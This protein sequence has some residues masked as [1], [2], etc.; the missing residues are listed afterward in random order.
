ML[1]YNFPYLKIYENHR[2][3]WLRGK[4]LEILEL[5]FYIPERNIALEIQGRQHY[6]YVPFFH[7]EY[8]N[9]LIQLERDRVK[10]EICYGR[11]IK[12]FEISS[13]FELDIF[14]NDFKEK[15]NTPNEEEK[16]PVDQYTEKNFR[17]VEKITLMRVN[18]YEKMKC[19]HRRD[20]AAW[21]VAKLLLF[22]VRYG[23]ET[24]NEK[25]KTFYSK[26]KEDIDKKFN[27]SLRSKT[28]KYEKEVNKGVN[29]GMGENRR[30]VIYAPQDKESGSTS[31]LAAYCSVDIL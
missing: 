22:K 30:S 28:I 10:K 3:E 15:E 16:Y 26:N 25:I 2:P 4:S 29:Y 9:Y 5:D 14:I 17:S 20:T 23:I 13:A 12:L 7:G 18:R 1:Y 6:E 21:K 11:N 19:E 31:D 24:D 8:D 27:Q